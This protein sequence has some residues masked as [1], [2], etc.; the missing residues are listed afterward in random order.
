MFLKHSSSTYRHEPTRF[1]I[2]S[3]VIMLALFV[4][5]KLYCKKI[6]VSDVHTCSVISAA[7]SITIHTVYWQ[8]SAYSSMR[9]FFVFQTARTHRDRENERKSSRAWFE[10][11]QIW[12]QALSLWDE[13]RGGERG[14]KLCQAIFK[15]QSFSKL[16]YPLWFAPSDLRM[17]ALS[18]SRK[19][20]G[21]LGMLY[22]SAGEAGF[23]RTWPAFPKER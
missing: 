10:G 18:P 13:E 2:K 17:D 3:T 9:G 5:T 8:M 21:V 7:I 20:R 23:K 11:G 22:C 14:P 16:C 19:W 1:G 4:C 15:W 12:Q 6:T